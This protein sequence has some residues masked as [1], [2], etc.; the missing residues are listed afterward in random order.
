MR[1][2]RPNRHAIF[3]VVFFCVGLAGTCLHAQAPRLVV[4]LVMDQMRADFVGR[5]RS[6]FNPEGLGRLLREGAVFADCLYDYDATETAPG[7]AVIATGSY[8]RENGMIGNT[9]YDRSRKALVTSIAD[10]AHR[11]VGGPQADAPGASPAALHGTAL[12]DEMRR[13]YGDQSHVVAVSW[14]DRAAVLLGGK[15]PNAAF[16]F[17]NEAEGFVTSTYYSNSLPDWVNQFNRRH[18]LETNRGKVWKPLQGNAFERTVELLAGPRG[19]AQFWAE[20]SATP[21]ASEMLFQFAEAAVGTYGLGADATPDLLAISVSAPD[22]AGHRLGPDSAIVHDLFLRI[23]RQL[24]EFLQFLDRRVGLANVVVALS[25]DHGVSPLP[26]N[27]RAERLG[28]GRTDFVAIVQKVEQALAEQFGP[29][30]WIERTDNFALYLSRDAIRRKGLDLEKVA[31]AAGEAAIRQPGIAGYYT[32]AQLAATQVEGP[33]Q[34]FQSLYARSYYPG[35]SGDVMLRVEPFYIFFPSG[36]SHGSPYTYDR[37]VPLILWGRAFQAGTHYRRVSPADIAPTLAAIL[38][39]SPPALAVGRVL[40]EALRVPA[41]PA[42]AGTP[43][44]KAP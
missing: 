36:T 12:G 10:P 20:F 44:E 29:E 33:S 2:S 28:G 11:R 6:Q 32:A 5:F 7:H 14:K 15:N 31:V 4:V 25:S 8:P 43:V 9:W 37:H 40:D 19:R 38:E 13:A 35:R 27:T 42:R 16:W 1:R 41:G 18:A 34:S 21:F 23:D 17:D 39:I 30:D 26:E 3:A 22:F 24:A